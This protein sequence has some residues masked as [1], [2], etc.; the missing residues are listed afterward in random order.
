VSLLQRLGVAA[1]FAALLLLA[2]C[3]YVTLFAPRP[4]LP[5]GS[6]DESYDPAVMRGAVA[7]AQV[8]AHQQDIIGMGSRF[9]GQDGFYKTADYIRQAY[10]DAGLELLEYENQTVAPWTLER[11]ILGADG[12]PLSNV[13]LFPYFPNYI[14]PMNTPA[15]GLAGKLVLVTD[16]LLNT[17][18]KFDDCIALID[19]MK[20]PKAFGVL[21]AKYA[22][23]GFKAMIVS[24]RDGLDKINWRKSLAVGSLPMNYVRVVAAPG[25]FDHLDE[26]VTLRV[27]TEYRKIRNPILVGILRAGVADK[28]DPSA[29]II[30]AEY[31]APSILPD[32]A[33]GELSAVPA[34]TQLAM[35]DGLKSYKAHLRRDVV[36][37]ATGGQVAAQDS[38]ARLLSIL[39]SAHDPAPAR[40]ALVKERDENQLRLAQL[41][42]IIRL[43][44]DSRFLHDA[45]A[46]ESLVAG[47]KKDERNFFEEQFRYVMNTILLERTEAQLQA[48]IEFLKRMDSNL[49][50][51]EFLAYMKMKAGYDEAL[52]VGGYPLGKLV[53]T[54][55]TFITEAD[56]I[57]RCV[58]RFGTLHAFHEAEL[59]RSRQ[60]L[61]IHDAIHQYS[62]VVVV[63][64]QILPTEPS[65]TPSESMTVFMG[66][67]VEEGAYVQYPLFNNALLRR[68]N[69]LRAD[70]DKEGSAADFAAFRYESIN[71]A[72]HSSKIASRV[73]DLNTST[74]YWNRLSYPSVSLINTDRT[75]AYELKNSPISKPFM[76]DL[77]TM[78]HSLHVAGET[79]LWLAHGNGWFELP[80]KA[81]AKTFNGCVYV[82]G[83]G[84]SVV[85]NY[86]LAGALFAPKPQ[87]QVFQQFGYLPQM[88]DITDPYGR[89]S[90]PLWATDVVW[91]YSPEIAG[92]GPNG[93]IRYM[94][95]DGSI[96]QSVYKSN[97]FSQWGTSALSV[98][99]VVF[100]AAPVGILDLIN[101]Q[102]LTAYGAVDL[103]VRDGLA[104]LS[105]F[106]KY[107]GEEG[108]LTFVEPELF[109][110][111]ELKAGAADSPST[112]A[113]RAFLLG[114]ESI[115]ATHYPL[116]PHKEIDGPGYLAA[117]SLLIRD[118][119][120]RVASAM[121]QVD[122]RRLEL[123]E[124]H[125]MADERVVA[126]E[127]RAHES[128]EASTQPGISQHQRTLLSQESVTYSTLN[129]PVLRGAISEAVIGVLW[130]L[131]LLVPFAFFFEKLVFGFAD[132]RKQIITQAMVILVVFALLKLLHP[133]FEMIRSSLMILLGFVILL[134][135]AGITM[136]FFGKF[137][138][139]L[140]ELR[141]QR[142]KVTA[143]EIN[144]FGV[145]GTAFMLGLNNM[146]RRKVRTGLTCATLVLITFAMICFTSVTS[147]LKE[148]AVA[149]GKA[150]YQGFLLKPDSFYP[151]GEGDFFALQNK[152]AHMYT[153]APR[154][155][156]VGE[157]TWDQ[158][159]YNPQLD[160]VY[161]PAA[162]AATQPDAMAISRKVIANSMLVLSN[163]E[164]L[165]EKIKLL[166]NRGWFPPPPEKMSTKDPIL[167]ML[168]E[169][170]AGNLGLNVR[171]VNAGLPTV[172]VCGKL[173]SV[174]GIFAG[175]SL[176]EAR[177]LDGRNLLPFDAEAIATPRVA[178]SSLLASLNDPQLSPERV[179]LAASRPFD[180][181][182]SAHAGARL[183]S[184]AVEFNALGYK[185]AKSAINTQ[186]EQSGNETYY[187]LDGIAYIG[188]LARA[189]SFA[190]LAG[191]LVPL[192]VAAL[193]VLNTMRGSVYERKDEIFVYNAVG[194]APR[195]VFFMFF[196][197]AFVYAV[198]GAV[199]G[200]LLS[201]GLGRTLTE[202]EAVTGYQWTGGMRMTF[203]NINTI[204]A[205][206]AV[207]V[208]VFV[209]TYFPARSAGRIATPADDQ[210]WSLPPAQDDAIAFALPFTFDRK[211][212]IAV[213]EFFNRI[214]MDHG[215][216]GTGTFHAGKPEFAA[217]EDSAGL[218]P[219]IRT[220]IWLKPFDL[221]VSQELI[222]RM[223]TDPETGEFIARLQLTRLSGTRESWMRLNEGFVGLVR[224]NFLYWRAV[225][226]EE[227]GRLFD[228]ARQQIET[229]VMSAPTDVAAEVA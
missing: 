83:V 145:I 48:K 17:R 74:T 91:P 151:I 183:T 12:K 50:S 71:D 31:D 184:V 78:Q 155:M 46:T 18:P 187:G 186:L 220:T 133:A 171:D 57:K 213:L 104:D 64:P 152:Y 67:G 6:A 192:L 202:L 79:M 197:E 178:G 127:K 215:E 7:P 181:L 113:T 205:S 90:R 195:Y 194:I 41:D 95:D 11:Q 14:Q 154:T 134:I 179:I 72:K 8:A 69:R 224:K 9:I 70:A 62:T 137:Q 22:Q 120:Q 132:V 217:T 92:Y 223:P 109:L 20:Q 172:K 102:T 94:K 60:A 73:P 198:V 144:T 110:Y 170:M 25:I 141:K 216:G 173:C 4:P 5:T 160:I 85:P 114:T 175:A 226:P 52:A 1:I 138:E 16:E 29:L 191:L 35:L 89:Y 158:V 165:Q 43:C 106:Y 169:S 88:M 168:P 146:H 167:I 229:A 23:V 103:I 99:V 118:I 58:D 63:A 82:A 30:P 36:F 153:V 149:V 176:A 147:D 228:A 166:T 19:A 122:D 163:R 56:L 115:A 135:S 21:W 40:K 128:L 93:V 53:A 219:E 108:S 68:T 15:E 177:D 156:Y 38:S 116:D 182:S 37:I 221:G 87:Y 157:R 33:P 84:K 42:A 45:A 28:T 209:S 96:G 185:D 218:I 214:F 86:P 10:R 136:L 193:T 210:G 13:E 159:V 24:S 26:P 66:P 148:K 65:K 98:N 139:N 75:S 143:A 61:A 212:R 34:A 3:F 222:I 162:Q 76:R 188:Q 180:T 131:G 161:D 32:L 112:Q 119:P 200:F 111:V 51:P 27:R 117:D 204:F 77:G 47:L 199:L 124:R 101:P 142:G 129:H 107:R 105:R 44:A 203:T 208:A 2:M 39:G 130:Y 49:E 174:W 55:A 164:P 225:S 150:P 207:A 126:F 196:A 201:Q 81:G 80:L 100:R 59:G 121:L 125:H 140:D 206:I 123:Q 97:N 211:D 227:R 190:G 54:S 189:T